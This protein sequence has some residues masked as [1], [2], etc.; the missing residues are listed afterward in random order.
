RFG[1]DDEILFRA[2]EQNSAFL[3][4]IRSNGDGRE[5]IAEAPGTVW[6]TASPDGEWVSCANC[7]STRSSVFSTSGRSPITILP[8][9]QSTRLRWSG[10]GQVYLSIQYGQ[11]SAFGTG[12]TYILPAGSDSVLPLIPP[13]GFHTESEIA[14][15][16]GVK[17]IPY[18][19][20]A[21]GPTASIYAYS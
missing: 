1:R 16:P 19:D 9:A 5:K 20:V 10:D 17:I 3:Y 14:A 15:A 21:P 12:K 13:G 11:A 7:D 4:R 2:I 8:S 6:G 18:G